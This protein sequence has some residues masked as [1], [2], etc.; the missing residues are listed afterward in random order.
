MRAIRKRITVAPRA[1]I[2]HFARAFGANGGIRRDFGAR[3]AIGAGND[4]KSTPRSFASRAPLYPFDP[5]QRRWLPPKPFEE[6]GDARVFPCD[7]DQHTS[8]IVAHIT[9]QAA[10]A[11]KPPHGGAKA[12]ALYAPLHQEFRADHALRYSS[13][14]G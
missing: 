10:F 11:C 8:G 1:R 14:A 12:H 2:E 5:C 3:L 6:A 4:V 13:P 7:A 9:G